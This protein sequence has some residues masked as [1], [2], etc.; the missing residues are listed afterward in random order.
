MR[1]KTRKKK[2]HSNSGGSKMADTFYLRSKDDGEAIRLIRRYTQ[3]I[4]TVT[5]I[6]KYS[7]TSAGRDF[8]L[9]NMPDAIEKLEAQAKLKR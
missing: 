6:S 3:L 7:M 9:C 8:I 4:R 2:I 5:G 1:K